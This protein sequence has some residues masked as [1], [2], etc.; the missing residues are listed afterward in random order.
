MYKNYTSHGKG[1][2]KK[3]EFGEYG[4]NVV[5]EDGVLV[6]HPE[7]IYLKNNVY[8]GHI[9]VLKAYYKNKL[10]IGK[11][12]WVG[13]GCFFNSA[14]S[15]VIGKTV[16]I[17]PYVKILTSQHSTDLSNN[18]VMRND[19]IFDGVKIGDGADIGIGSV[20]LPGVEIGKGAIIAAGSV[21]TKNI[22]KFSIWGG[23]PAKFMKS[24]T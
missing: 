23:V 18:D 10:I 14:G 15:I 5:I 20:I 19:L 12:S 24:R 6:F 16:G 21:V 1:R 17:G 22:P 4:E 13:Q 7:N 8:V 9:T 2:F 11:N 3:N